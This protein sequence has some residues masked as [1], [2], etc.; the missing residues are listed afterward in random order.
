MNKEVLNPKKEKPKGP[1][2]AFSVQLKKLGC[3]VDLIS[4][5]DIEIKNFELEPS[6]ILNR[7]E[8][9]FNPVIKAH[10]IEKNQLEKWASRLAEESKK[11]VNWI[12]KQPH[13]E[14]YEVIHFINPFTGEHLRVH[15]KD[16]IQRIYGVFVRF[17][18]RQ[19]VFETDKSFL[20]K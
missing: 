9:I 16:E 17:E 7:W 18:P 12:K 19:V 3:K 11:I 6:A 5:G 13:P 10:N 20:K 4:A 15:K 8:K 2:S 1:E 14:E